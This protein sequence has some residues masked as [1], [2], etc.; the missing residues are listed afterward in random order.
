M[1]IVFYIHIAVLAW[2]KPRPLLPKTNWDPI[3]K[4]PTLHAL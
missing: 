2:Q 3:L 4:K 1:K